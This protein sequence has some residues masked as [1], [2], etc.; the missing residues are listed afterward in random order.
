MQAFLLCEFFARFRGRRVAIK[1]S[2]EFEEVYKRVS[3]LQNLLRRQ[4]A[5]SSSLFPGSE[6]SCSRFGLTPFC[7]AVADTDNL[8]RFSR[9]ARQKWLLHLA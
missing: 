5:G 9:M 1:P 8:N 6:V 3:D 2:K 4:V 7:R